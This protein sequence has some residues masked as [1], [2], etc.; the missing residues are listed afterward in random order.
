MGL[1]TWLRPPRFTLPVFLA[2]TLVPAAALVWLGWRVLDFDRA[3]SRQQVRDRLE[4]AADRVAAGLERELDEIA[5]RMLAWIA[6]PPAALASHGALV[7]A[8]GPTGIETRAGAA[9]A[10]WAGRRSDRRSASVAVG[11][12]RALRISAKRASGGGRDPE[13]ARALS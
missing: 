2:V 12:G 11:G 9:A 13:R 6:S 4:Y 1:R 10:V 3:L 5:D 8:L 7:A